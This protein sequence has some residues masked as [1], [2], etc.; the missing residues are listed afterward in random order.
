MTDE[1]IRRQKQILEQ[2]LIVLRNQVALVSKELDK[3]NTMQHINS[4]IANQASYDYDSE[5]D[6]LYNYSDNGH[7]LQK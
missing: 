5:D 4:Y 1:E 3:L 2:D 7:F 6:P